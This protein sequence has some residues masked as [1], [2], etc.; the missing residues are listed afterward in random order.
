MAVFL[1][2]NTGIVSC[3]FLVVYFFYSMFV[4]WVLS[5]R[6]LKTF[7]NY[8]AFFALVRLGAQVCGVAY[9]TQG[10]N[11][12]SLLAAYMV[13]VAMG[14]L[15]LIF[16]TL[17]VTIHEQKV[18]FGRSWIESSLPIR[19]PIKLLNTPFGIVRAILIAGS[20]T[21]IVGGV[22]VS[23]GLESSSNSE[24]LLARTLRLAGL[25][26]YTVATLISIFWS[27]YAFF[28][29]RI[30]TPSLVL[31][32]VSGPF[33][34]VRVVFNFLSIYVKKMN[35]FHYDNVRGLTVNSDY[36]VYEAILALLMEFC[37]CV[38]LSAAFLLSVP[39]AERPYS[40]Y[41]DEEE[42]LDNSK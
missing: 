24:E 32:L 26:C 27:W 5:K 19:L 40:Q 4:C 1:L 9:A 30:R 34:L 38:L 39:T 14:F 29:E 42:K 8:L 25:I 2:K 28:A 6:G 18:K 16:T 13:L 7:F 36:V 10:F 21:F 20:V 37:I 17:R 12:V 22:Y 11:N 41:D 35:Q 31:V 3:V 23:N 15:A 33:M